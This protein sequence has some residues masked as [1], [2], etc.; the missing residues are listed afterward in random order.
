MGYGWATCRRSP[1]AM[2]LIEEYLPAPL[3]LLGGGPLSTSA[4]VTSA[5]AMVMRRP[6]SKT[7]GSR[8]P[9]LEAPW[10][11]DESWLPS[12]GQGDGRFRFTHA[13][14]GYGFDG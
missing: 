7:N 12:I 11:R 9:S 4:S 6:I 5:V 10:T 13:R 1:N 3:R 8:V 14:C 2:K